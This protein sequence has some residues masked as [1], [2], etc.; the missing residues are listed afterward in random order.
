M[1]DPSPREQA[2]TRFRS[3]IAQGRAVIGAGAGIGL[4]AKALDAGG[5]DFL[6]VYNSGRFRMAGHGSLAGLMPYGNANMTMLDMAKE[7]FSVVKKETPVFAGI[8][9]TDPFVNMRSLLGDVR[10]LGFVG[11]QNFPTVGLIG[12]GLTLQ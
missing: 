9:A 1:G 11:V 6:V 3:T 4:S 5:I 7:V 10:K 8:C 12:E 2:L